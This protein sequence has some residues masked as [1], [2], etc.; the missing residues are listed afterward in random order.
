MKLETY[1]CHHVL[2]YIL[3]YHK[4][5]LSTNEYYPDRGTKFK[6]AIK[7]VLKRNGFQNIES[8]RYHPQSQE[9]KM[10]DYMAHG[11]TQGRLDILNGAP[12]TIA[13]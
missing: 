9:N 11:K 2:T 8:R 7:F 10:K 3:L 12:G 6:G 1:L 5:N 13:L 4:N